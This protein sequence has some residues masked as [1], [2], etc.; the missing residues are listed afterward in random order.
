[1][2]LISGILSLIFGMILA[3]VLTRSITQP[4]EKAVKISEDVANGIITSSKNM[5]VGKDEV[6]Q[7]LLSLGKMQNNLANTLG[8]INKGADMVASAS[9]QIAAG[10]MDLSSRTEEQASALEETAATMEELTSVIKQNS[11]NSQ[12]ANKLALNASNQAQDGGIIV[13]NVVTKMKDIQ[14]SSQ[15]IVEIIS[16]IDSIAFQTNI[17]ALNAAV[18]A[19]RAGDQGKGFAVVANEVRSLARKSAESAKEI[20]G[21]IENS[22]NTVAEGNKLVQEAGVKM[23]DIVQSI[24]NVS[25]V[26]SEISSANEEQSNGID[27]IN[28]AVL[29]MDTV[30]QQNAALVEEAAAAAQSLE[31]QGKQLN[32]LVR[33]FKIS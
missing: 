1:M 5:A 23:D 27:Q 18:E 24:K 28:Q 9:S 29:Q 25:H 15:K 12:E 14:D 6:S 33:Q 4:L 21:L 17:L 30:T 16:V 3:Y 13:K 7:L 19:A 8:E 32:S 2:L 31:E 10:N 11:M 26:I 22:T 20:K